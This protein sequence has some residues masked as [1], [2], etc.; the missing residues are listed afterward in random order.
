MRF[1][2]LDVGS[3][4]T[5]VAYGDTDIGIPFPLETIEHSTL[6][7]LYEVIRNFIEERSVDR[8]IIGLPLLPS[9]D[10]GEQVEY[11]R[12]FLPLLDD[13]PYE[14][15]DER[16]TTPKG[17]NGDGDSHAACQI[18]SVILDRQ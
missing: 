2:A 12:S 1:L 17:Q 10:E 4:R 18:L 16:Y 13:F 5:G 14:L 15:V 6:Q 8:L 7:E 3:R 9:G 11:V